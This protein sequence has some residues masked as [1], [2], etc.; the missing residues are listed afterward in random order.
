MHSEFG[1]LRGSRHRPTLAISNSIVTK[2]RAPRHIY[3]I[4][5]AP[6]LR[7]AMA[8]TAAPP[9]GGGASMEC[10]VCFEHAS[11]PVVTL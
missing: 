6:A 5:G 9:G 2:Q 3:F 1:C 8:D 4:R 11:E 7:K 10:N